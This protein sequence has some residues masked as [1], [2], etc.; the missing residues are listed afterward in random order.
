MQW[1]W[2][3]EVGEARMFES[4]RLWLLQVKLSFFYNK[5]G[6]CQFLKLNEF[7]EFLWEDYILDVFCLKSCS[8]LS[9][10]VCDR[11]LLLEF[12]Q[13]ARNLNMGK[14]DSHLKGVSF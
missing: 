10:C 3:G 4:L 7:I 14:T 12:R 11:G 2:C 5:L 1:F 8:Q 9:F 6:C 13:G